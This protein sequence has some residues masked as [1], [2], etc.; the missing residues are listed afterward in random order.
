[1]PASDEQTTQPLPQEWFDRAKEVAEQLNI[2]LPDEQMTVEEAENRITR[3]E[4]RGGE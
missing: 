2:P 3:F 1:M 4:Q